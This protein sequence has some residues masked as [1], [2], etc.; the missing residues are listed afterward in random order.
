MPM[1]NIRI[2]TAAADEVPAPVIAFSYLNLDL[3]ATKHPKP[4]GFGCFL[5]LIQSC[6][7]LCH[8]FCTSSFS[9][10]ISRSLVMLR[11]SSSLVMVT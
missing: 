8:T 10:S 2:R 6:C 9:S 3:Q 5:S 4:Y 11:T 1:E 7:Q